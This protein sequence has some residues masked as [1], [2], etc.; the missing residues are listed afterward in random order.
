MKR[1][2][3]LVC[4]FGLSLPAVVQASKAQEFT[5]T[6]GLKLIVKEDHRAP[7]VVTQVWYK[8]GSSYEHLG[9][10][11]V[12]HVLEHMMFKGTQQFK[13]GEFS[14]II[15]EQGGQENAFTGQDYT[16]YYQ[17]LESSR[18]ETS[19]K[20]EADRMHNLVLLE[21]EFKKEVEVVKEE[22]RMRTDD[23]PTRKTAEIFH[24]A[25][26]RYS[27]YSAPIIGWMNDLDNMRLSDLANWYKLWYA[28]NNATIV[29]VGD[30]NTAFIVYLAK[31]Y[32]GAIPRVDMPPLKPIH[33][34][35]QLGVKRL[36]VK[37]PAKVPYMIMGYKVPV[38]NTADIEWEPYALEVLINVLDGGNS[39]RFSKT[40][41]R[42]K[43]IAASISTSYSASERLD[44]LLTFSAVPTKNHTIAD[45]EHA[46]RGQIELMKTTL[47][48][49][50][51]LNRVKAQVM[52]D[53]IYQQDSGFYQAMQMGSLETTGVGWRLLDSYVDKLKA[54]TA[55]QVQTV[56]KK[57]LIDKGLTIAE[58]KPQPMTKNTQLPARLSTGRH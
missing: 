39:S 10:T 56:A 32:F 46:L 20:M 12:S 26:F 42:E 21:D 16:G 54:V 1:I 4:L 6:N 43:S 52:A 38:I 51:E 8:V 57:Y 49:P 34:P 29:V 47:V 40:L 37:L 3:S 36:E 15:S 30:V 41:I 19:F 23:K 5:L 50:A 18:V 17:K 28:P 27:P 44:T 11:G 13:P 2:L 35:E 48:T 58:L 9:V 25:A 45:V 33:E 22:R 31:K 55:E 53:T 14:R 24:A 7:V